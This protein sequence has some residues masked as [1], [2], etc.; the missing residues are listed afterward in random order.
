L[1][2]DATIVEYAGGVPPRLEQLSPTSPEIFNYMDKLEMYIQ[3]ISGV[4]GI[5]RGTP[6]PGIR[7]GVALQFLDE[8]EAERENNGVSKRN[9]AIR[10]AAK[11]TI[12]LMGQHYKDE[13]GRLVRLLGKDNTYYIRSFRRADFS[14]IYDVRIQNSSALPDQKSA[15]IQSIIDL[16]QSFPRLFREEQVV[17]MLDL[18]TIDSFK[19]K[20]TVS[21]KCAESENDSILNNEPAA[22]PKEWEDLLI[23][24]AIHVKALQERSFKEEV[25]GPAQ[26]ALIEH[27]KITE[28]LMW[29]RARTNGL[30]KQELL[31][32]DNFPIFFTLDEEMRMMVAGNMPVPQ[33]PGT[34]AINPE[35]KVSRKEG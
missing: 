18:G 10:E 34:A 13:D 17:D 11:Q 22:E 3:K 12:A 14:K 26:A 2:N 7:A 5:S 30:F 35:V 32:L 1:G 4:H 25:P 29:N 20:A 8:Q 33:S 9:S 31:M 27:I 24:Y 21:V 23:H 28:M 15:K 6:P 19:D 16:S